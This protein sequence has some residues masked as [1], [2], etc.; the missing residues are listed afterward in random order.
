MSCVPQ[1]ASMFPTDDRLKAKTHSLA[2]CV[3]QGHTQTH[4]NHLIP[5]SPLIWARAFIAIPI[6]TMANEQSS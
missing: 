2:F 6:L 3:L 1:K 5:H 4:R